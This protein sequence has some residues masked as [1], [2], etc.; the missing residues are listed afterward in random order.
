[1]SQ[2]EKMP[3]KRCPFCGG[4][5]G[6]L[7]GSNENTDKWRVWC[8]RPSSVCG[9]IGPFKDS[10]AEAIAAW[11]RRAL[12]SRDDVLEE[13]ARVADSRAVPNYNTGSYLASDIAAAIRS[14]KSKDTA[15]G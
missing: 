4:E 10:E 13:A 11:N 7:M 6:T 12:P 8:L 3:L 9:L 1:M 14:L 2:T 15:D 5:A